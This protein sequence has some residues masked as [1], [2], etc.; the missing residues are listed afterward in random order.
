M[1]IPIYEISISVL[2]SSNVDLLIGTNNADLL[3]QRDFRQGD[4]NEPLAIKTCLGWMLMGV[5]SNSSNR[6]KAKSYNPITKVSNE[7][8]S[9]QI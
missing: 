8:L 1:I 6:E 3:V 5:Y 4:T 7:S 9:K 2:N